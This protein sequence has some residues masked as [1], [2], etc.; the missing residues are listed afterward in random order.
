M[1]WR[2]D[3]VTEE[4]T[5]KILE[6]AERCLEVEGDYVEFECYK[7]DM[8]LLLAEVLREYNRGLMVE[9]SVEKVG[10]KA[11]DEWSGREGIKLV[12]L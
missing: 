6:L 1:S 12:L 7:G 11:V 2:N 10:D 4:E 3:Q 5:R 8:S 9:K